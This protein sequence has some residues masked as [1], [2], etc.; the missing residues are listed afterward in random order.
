MQSAAASRLPTQFTTFSKLSH[1]KSQ[2]VFSREIAGLRNNYQ[3]DMQE[4]LGPK[5]K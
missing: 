4:I 1:Q 3:S 2:N 5:S